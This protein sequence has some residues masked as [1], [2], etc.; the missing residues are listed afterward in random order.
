MINAVSPYCRIIAQSKTTF[1]SC[2]I[3]GDDRLIVGTS[4][5]SVLVYNLENQD[6]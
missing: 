5:G 6:G 2:K 4:S 3:I 1:A